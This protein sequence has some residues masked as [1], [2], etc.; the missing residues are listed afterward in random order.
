MGDGKIS[1]LT[2]QPHRLHAVRWRIGRAT[3]ALTLV[4]H[5]PG[6]IQSL[7]WRTPSSRLR[8][9]WPL[10]VDRERDIR[11][12][13]AERPLRAS[14]QRRV[15]ELGADVKADDTVPPGTDWT[16][17]SSDEPIGRRIPPP[18]SPVCDAFR[19]SDKTEAGDHHH[20]GR[21]LRN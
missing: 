10:A 17:P 13:V 15:T 14:L 19:G 21:R 6:S 7:D 11:F 4:V 3:R 2:G 1:A 18:R 5:F 9:E 20:P 16:L 12:R 8:Q